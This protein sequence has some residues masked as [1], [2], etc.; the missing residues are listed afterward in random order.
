MT[1]SVWFGF[2]ALVIASNAYGQQMIG[3]CP[4]LPANNIWNTPV[5]TLPVLSN[6]ASM[7]T[8]I[9]ASTGFHPDFGTFAGY[10]IPFITVPGTQTKYSASFLYAD[11]SDPGPYAVPLNAPIEGGSGSTGDRHALAVDVDNC[12]LYELYRAFPQSSSWTADAGAIFDLRSNALR[13]DTWTS[14]DA[15]GLPIV[16]GLITYEEVASGE[17]KH[18]LRFTAPQS[19]RAYVWPARHYAS[20]LTGTQYPRMGERFRLKAGFD[21]TP[22]PADVQVILRAMKKYGIILADNGSAWYLSGKSDPRWNDTTLHQ[23]GQVLGSNLEAVDATVLMT[24]PNSGAAVQNGVTVAVSPSTASV[25]VSRQQAFTATVTGAP[26]GV[27]WS[28]NGVTG[29]NTSVGLIDASG[30]YSAPAVVP[31][32]N[33][34]TVRGTSTAS[35]SSSGTAS[36]TIIPHTSVTSVSPSPITV[37][38][39]TLTVNGAGF[40]P[41][42]IVSFDGQALPTT[43]TSSSV[44]KATGSAAAARTAVPVVVTG[45]DGDVSSTFF[46][47]VVAAAPVSITISPASATV[48]IKRTHQFTATV[49]NTSDTSVIWKVNGVV[50]GTAQAGTI[51]TS[52]LYRAPNVAPSPAVVSV[53]ATAAADTSKTASAS[54]TI[55]RR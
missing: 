3:S 8:T 45:P 50:G 34:V 27:T 38:S 10:G 15:A 13:P 44:L 32:P 25:R 31:S 9:G 6:S 54:V 39:F 36:A 7:V 14:A 40:L 19:R 21:I 20:S 5:D 48:R 29:G 26:A 37:G 28:V 33:V 52:G 55:S 46:V 53:S 51:S 22:F 35:P 16:P 47:D 30:N 42:A 49:S 43:F 1:R 23:L 24:D 41:G 17:I 2:A 18:A 4:V 12:V 11:E